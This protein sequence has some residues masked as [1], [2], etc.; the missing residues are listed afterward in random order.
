MKITIETDFIVATV[1]S[2][3]EFQAETEVEELRRLFRGAALAV[4]F[5]PGSVAEM[6]GEDEP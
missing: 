6:L 1:A 3:P 5:Q 4:E 2:K